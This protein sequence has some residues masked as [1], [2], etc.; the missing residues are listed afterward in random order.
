MGGSIKLRQKYA[1]VGGSIKLR[2]K[3]SCVG[4]SVKL[5]GKNY[6]PPCLTTLVGPLTHHDD[7]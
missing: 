5:E 6:V 3:Y 2:Q 7:S 1:C 4:G